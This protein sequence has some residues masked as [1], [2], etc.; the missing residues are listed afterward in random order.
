MYNLDAENYLL[1]H[2]DPDVRAAA[3]IL[4]EERERVKRIL[5]LVRDSLAQVRL[6]V[7]YL[8]FD[9]EATTRER[10]FLLEKHRG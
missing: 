7:K 2:D 10:N 5:G 8:I 3:T 6:D 4:R 9:L 1:S